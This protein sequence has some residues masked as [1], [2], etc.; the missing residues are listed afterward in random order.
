MLVT[1]V[2]SL[3][4]AM[5]L[6]AFAGGVILPLI[7]VER[8]N[9]AYCLCFVGLLV[10]LI[11]LMG[12]LKTHRRDSHSQKLPSRHVHP[13][14]VI[15]LLCWFGGL[16]AGISIL[17]S[18]VT[19]FVVPESEQTLLRDVKAEEGFRK[20]FRVV[21]RPGVPSLV[22]VRRGFEDDVQAEFRHAGITLEQFSE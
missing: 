16:S 2:L 1:G 15:T 18:G 10:A 4:S 12:E 5:N 14:I 8:L 13:L 6:G 22:Y 7:S 3:L 21:S 17:K 11:V 20:T 19:K 9:I